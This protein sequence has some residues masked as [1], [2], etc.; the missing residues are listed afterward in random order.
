MFAKQV[1]GMIV[2]GKQSLLA[3]YLACMVHSSEFVHHRE[4]FHTS[5]GFQLQVYDEVLSSVVKVGGSLA[6]YQ[7]FINLAKRGAKVFENASV[8]DQNIAKLS[9]SSSSS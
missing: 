9:Q 6:D 1:A 2:D 8:T 7:N 4:G 3:L 5:E